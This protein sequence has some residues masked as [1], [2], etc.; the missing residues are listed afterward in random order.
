M[1]KK[2]AIGSLSP[3]IIFATLSRITIIL[4]T[5]GFDIFLLFLVKK[6]EDEG[7]QIS[8]EAKSIMRDPALKNSA[9]AVIHLIFSI[10][11]ITMYMTGTFD[12]VE[13]PEKQCEIILMIFLCHFAIRSPVFIFGIMKKCAKKDEDPEVPEI[14][15][16]VEGE[17]YILN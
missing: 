12:L 14:R 8:T 5:I 7:I 13:S 1:N 3:I 4:L 17:V 6:I 9:A 16:V 2:P 11:S 15:L 10:A